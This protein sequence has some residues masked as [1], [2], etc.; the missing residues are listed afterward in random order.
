MGNKVWFG[1]GLVG[2]WFLIGTIESRFRVFF[3][4]M[5]NKNAIG[6]RL[7]QFFFING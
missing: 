2:S 7:G 5:K 3:L 6:P 1:V 4:K